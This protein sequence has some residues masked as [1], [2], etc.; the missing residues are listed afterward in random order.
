MR[1]GGDR[2]LA[3]PPGHGVPHPVHQ[4]RPEKAQGRRQEEPS[5]GG[6]RQ[7]P[8]RLAPPQEVV[9]SQR[10]PERRSLPGGKVRHDDRA[11]LIGVAG[12]GEEG[13]E[14]EGEERAEEQP[15]AGGGGPPQ[16]P[17]AREQG[18]H[19]RAEVGR[20]IDQ[21]APAGGEAREPPCVIARRND[22]REDPRQ[23]SPPVER[24]DL[25]PR[26]LP[27]RQP[28]GRSMQQLVQRDVDPPAREQTAEHERQTGPPAIEAAVQA[29]D[30]V[31]EGTEQPGQREERHGW[32]STP[33]EGRGRAKALD[34]DSV[35]W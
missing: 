32:Y 19:E 23:Q 2:P 5:P 14:G 11:D 12:Q 22:E 13:G 20:Q 26:H 16:P 3:S 25:Q 21:I 33:E 28:A 17:D 15:G 10:L 30:R 34:S 29:V 35:L 6:V 27:A 9:P 18:Q 1:S 7:S 4:K 8:E 24:I 31:E